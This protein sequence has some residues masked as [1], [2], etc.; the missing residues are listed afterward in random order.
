MTTICNYKKLVQNYKKL[1]Q[2]CK[3]LVRSIDDNIY[4]IVLDYIASQVIVHIV[5]VV[6]T[7]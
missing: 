6:G 5:Q 1:V 2:N 4:Y 7:W 3:K